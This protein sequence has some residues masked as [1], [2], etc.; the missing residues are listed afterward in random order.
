MLRERQKQRE[1]EFAELKSVV[2]F[3][4]NK[5]NAV[6]ISEP[7]SKVITNENGVPKAI[8]FTTMNNKPTAEISK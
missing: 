5:I 1:N 2:E 7:S 4:K 6:V 3:L 8:E